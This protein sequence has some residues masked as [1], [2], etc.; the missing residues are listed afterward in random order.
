MLITGNYAGLNEHR[1]I[2]FEE[3]KP[4][5][6]L[7]FTVCTQN[8]LIKLTVVEFKVVIVVELRVKYV[9]GYLD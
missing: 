4:L 5:P 3:F 6:P 9:D 7:I 8:K 1:W 2:P